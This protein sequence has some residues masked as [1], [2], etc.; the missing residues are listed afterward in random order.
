MRTTGLKV[1]GINVARLGTD[2]NHAIV[3]QRLRASAKCSGISKNPLQGKRA[4][5]IASEPSGIFRGMTLIP[6][7]ATPTFHG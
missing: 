6:S 2:K 5:I 7:I 3:D 4:H 1:E